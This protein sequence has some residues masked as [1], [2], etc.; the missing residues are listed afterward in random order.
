MGQTERLSRMG[1][2]TKVTV[3]EATLS[4]VAR[5]TLPS[6]SVLTLWQSNMHPASRWKLWGSVL[7]TR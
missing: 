6:P 1:M 3:A 4:R 5:L 2:V 7:S